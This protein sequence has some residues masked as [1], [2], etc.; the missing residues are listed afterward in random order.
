VLNLAVGAGETVR[1]LITL[2]LL[3]PLSFMMGW[4]M[5]AGLEAAGKRSQELVP[6]AWAVNGV[7]SVA[8]TPLS[9]MV[10]AGGGFL[11]VTL[12]AVACYGAVAAAAQWASS[13]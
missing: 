5:P 8:A 13:N 6:L 10:A 9:V 12:L 7:A 11:A 4:L 1:F 2:V 3:F